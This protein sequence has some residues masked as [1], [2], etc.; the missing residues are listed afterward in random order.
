MV[1]LTD[2]GWGWRGGGRGGVIKKTAQLIEYHPVLQE[3]A[4]SIPGQEHMPRFQT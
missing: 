1:G 4:G 3:V 2:Q